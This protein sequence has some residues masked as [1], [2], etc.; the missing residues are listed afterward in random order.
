M[1]TGTSLFN[2]HAMVLLHNGE[3]LLVSAEEGYHGDVASLKKHLKHVTTIQPTP[4]DRF[5][6]YSNNA[7]PT[8]PEVEG[9]EGEWADRY[10]THC[11]RK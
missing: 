4:G 2:D 5:D 3:P 10:T 7:G 1:T 6:L 11:F 9:Y 8:H